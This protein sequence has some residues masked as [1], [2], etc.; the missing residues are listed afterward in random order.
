MADVIY[1]K[2]GR[3]VRREGDILIRVDEAGEAYERDGCFFAAPIEP[4]MELP[5]LDDR[6]VE[7]TTN[8]LLDPNFER[9]IVSEG[10]AHHSYGDREWTERTRRVHVAIVNYRLRLRALVDLG[11]FDIDVIVRA[12]EA[13]EWA[14]GERDAP[15]RLRL[16][17][18]VTAALLPSV[19]GIQTRLGLDGNGARIEE[20]IAAEPHPNVWRPSYRVRPRPMP[21]HLRAEPKGRIDTDLPEAIALLAPVEGMTLRV[22]CVDRGRAFATTFTVSAVLAAGEPQ[23]WFPYGAG[24]IGTEMVVATR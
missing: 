23:R 9:L 6:A 11:D 24:V 21:F 12:A 1:R 17:P 10:I 2:H 19:G 18:N 20:R 8:G 14:E 3:V 7:R 5:P 13:L 4:R 16:A 22:L 15:R